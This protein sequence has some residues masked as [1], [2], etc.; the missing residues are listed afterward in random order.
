MHEH[1]TMDKT[2]YNFLFKQKEVAATVT[3]KFFLIVFLRVLY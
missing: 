2:F 3:S 1:V